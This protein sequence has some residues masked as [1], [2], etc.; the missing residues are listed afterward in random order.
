MAT[1][2]LPYETLRDL[3]EGEVDASWDANEGDSFNP[4]RGIILAVVACAPF[5]AAVYWLYQSM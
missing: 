3:D 5:W 2:P 4:I 1:Q